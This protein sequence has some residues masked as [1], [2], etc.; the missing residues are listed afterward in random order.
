MT[1]IEPDFDSDPE[2]AAAWDPSWVV[3]APD[4]DEGAGRL[5]DEA[6][7]P[8]LDVG[9]GDG[10][11]A[12]RLPS[13]SRW[14]GL[15]S[16]PEMLARTTA[17]PAVRADAR[18]LPFQDGSLGAVVCKYMLYHLGDP[19]VVITEAH[20]VLRPGGLFLAVTRSRSQD[21]ELVPGGYPASTFDA[22]DA[23]RLAAAVFGSE[24]VEVEPW[25]GPFLVLPDRE[26]V[27]TY[28]RHHR[29]PRDLADRV[30]TPL[31][32]TKRGCQV[33]ARKR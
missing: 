13:R 10:A 27:A 15:D 2:R 29:L 19:S 12:R 30:K 18:R 9:C 31:T 16:S 26:A 22:E 11:F 8:V 5:I 7:A 23:P 3:A 21:P 6:L 24:S 17:R 33:W 25:D 28:T 32:L 20:R 4:W 14:I 1:A